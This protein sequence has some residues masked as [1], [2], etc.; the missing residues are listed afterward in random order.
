MV[1]LNVGQGVNFLAWHVRTDG[2]VRIDGHLLLL[3]LHH[4]FE[5]SIYLHFRGFLLRKHHQLRD[6]NGSL[7]LRPILVNQVRLP[8]DEQVKLVLLLVERDPGAQSRDTKLFGVKLCR[9]SW[10]HSL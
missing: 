10:V 9:H 1:A 7:L 5:S 4:F 2:H 8:V 3:F 6:L